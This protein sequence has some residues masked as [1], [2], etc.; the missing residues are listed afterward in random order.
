MRQVKHGSQLEEQCLILYNGQ[1][2]YTIQQLPHATFISINSLSTAQTLWA[3]QERIWSSVH[4][5]SPLD[6]EG[7]QMAAHEAC[8]SRHEHAILFHPWLCLGLWLLESVH[9]HAAPL[10]H[11]L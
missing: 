10:C 9:L 5:V 1:G 7:A 11:R 3:A 4:L 2:T 6:E 8:S